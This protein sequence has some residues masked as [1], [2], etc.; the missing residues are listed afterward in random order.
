MGTTKRI[1][2][3]RKGTA[4]TSLPRKKAKFQH[5]SADDLP[6]KSVSRPF[7]AGIGFDDGILDFEEVE[8]VEVIYETTDGGRVVKFNVRFISVHL[9]L[10]HSFIYQ[11]IAEEKDE[12]KDK[13]MDDISHQE[14]DQELAIEPIATFDCTQNL[15]CSKRSSAEFRITAENLLPEWHKYALHPKILSA[16]HTKQFLSPTPIQKS[17][18]PFAFAGRDVIGIAQTVNRISSILSS[19]DG[20]ILYRD[21]ERR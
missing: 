8:G 16:L 12:A 18:L 6:W 17:A 21:P 9:Y 15:Q 14:T 7:E 5:C 11:V 20:Q 4:K 13:S 10:I 2:L 1:G 19:V 3:K